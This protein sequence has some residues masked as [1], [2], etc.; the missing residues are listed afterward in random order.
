MSSVDLDIRN[1]K[2]NSLGGR[3]IML[4]GNLDIQGNESGR[5]GLYVWVNIKYI[6]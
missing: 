4:N 3:I 5:K 1:V 6:F 2:E